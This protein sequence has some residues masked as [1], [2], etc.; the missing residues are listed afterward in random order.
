MR[1]CALVDASGVSRNRILVTG[2][3]RKKS[4]FPTQPLPEA[5]A[6]LRPRPRFGRFA[7]PIF[8]YRARAKKKHVS[9]KE[10]AFPILRETV[11]ARPFPTKKNGKNE[12]EKNRKNWEKNER[13]KGRR[14]TEQRMRACALVDA[15]DVS[16][17]RISV[18]GPGRKKSA[19]PAAS[20]PRLAPEK[21][22]S[23]GKFLGLI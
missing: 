12:N 17:N 1:V 10:R 19:F 22:G 15:S 20:L 21:R 23:R 4:V 7:K 18:T 8:G 9:A 6:G 14:K 13:K 16:R 11:L 2:P 3:G 5:Y